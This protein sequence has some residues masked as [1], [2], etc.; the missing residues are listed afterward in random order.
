MLVGST[1]GLQSN[2]T[3][4]R[5]AS[6]AEKCR[7]TCF[8]VFISKGIHFW[9]SLLLHLLCRCPKSFA[10]ELFPRPYWQKRWWHVASWYLSPSVGSHRRLV[11]VYQKPAKVTQ[12]ALLYSSA[13][14]IQG[15]H[16]GLF[17]GIFLCGG[18]CLSLSSQ[19][20]GEEKCGVSESVAQCQAASD[21]T[22]QTKKEK[23]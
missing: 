5:K 1:E 21:T 13:H 20:C 18:D 7:D 4:L 6:E 9:P 15:V 3:K 14:H 12:P 16:S 8:L 17:L 22:W 23:E 19:S 10:P 11:Q 2:Y